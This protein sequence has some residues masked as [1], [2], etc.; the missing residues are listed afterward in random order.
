[1]T[2]IDTDVLII[3][4]GA[5]GL[6][7]ALNARGRR[8]CVLWPGSGDE[9]RTAS[10]YAQGG[11]AAAVGPDDMPAWH[12][13]D[14]LRAG[15]HHNRPAAARIACREAPGVISYLESLGVSFTREGGEWSLHREAAHCRQRVLHAGGDATGAAI[16]QALR[17]QIAA[18]AHVEMLPCV[19]AV[20]LLTDAGAVHGATG[21]TEDGRSIAVHARDVVIATGGVGGLYSRST[22]P[23]DACGD[24]P[25]MALAAGARC[26][27]L[28]FVQFHPTAL[29]V[30]TRPLPLLTEALRGAGA[31]LIDDTGAL[32]MHGIHH[33]ADLA[34][35][36]VVAR[37]IYA[38]QSAGGRA[39]LD[40]TRLNDMEI[41]RAFPSAWRACVD[42]GFDPSR[43][44]VPVTPA[45]HYHMGGI[46]VDL[47]GRTS[48]P[49]LWAVGEA[50]CTGLHGANRLASNSLL[51]AVVFGRRAGRALRHEHGQRAT[52]VFGLEDA[53]L[54]DPVAERQLR[55]ILWRC[56]GLIRSMTGLGEGLTLV[57]RLRE[58]TPKYATLQQAR[59][60]LAEHMM[61]AAAR[62]RSSC[63]AHYRSD[64]AA[65][66]DLRVMGPVV[67]DGRAYGATRV[68]PDLPS[69]RGPQR[70][71][72]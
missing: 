52:C 54:P 67:D 48:L 64:G 22:N 69:A 21:L 33:L 38:A 10:D 29:D 60:L 15:C 7:T 49:G 70:I 19:R 26:N 68:Q 57:A 41:A 5:A 58:A 13:D 11:I 31:R 8:V 71:G 66:P 30:Q 61:L 23:P 63:G 9:P 45:A 53:Q 27:D 59:L 40:A 17:R 36:D 28:E 62:R 12:L 65:R 24:G 4:A 47:E 35:R 1:M 50:A 39:W 55:E 72:A 20:G 6:I 3:G 42:H 2:R 14:T 25:A 34:P 37:A 56:M 32:L 46:A 43:E 16:M 18:A 44:A 51:E